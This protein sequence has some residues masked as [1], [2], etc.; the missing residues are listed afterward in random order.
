MA[1]LWESEGAWIVFAAE[2]L[3]EVRRIPTRKPVGKYDVYNKI[4]R[5]EGT[6]H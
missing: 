6:S 3:R 4:S 2:V 5:S 1:S